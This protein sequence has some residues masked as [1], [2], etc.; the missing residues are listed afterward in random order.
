MEVVINNIITLKLGE[1]GYP[2]MFNQIYNPPKILYAIGN[3]ELLNSKCISMVGTR[4]PTLYG[5]KSAVNIARNLSDKGITVVSGLAKGIDAMSHEGALQGKSKATIAVLGNSLDL[6]D[7]YPS[8]NEYLYKKILYENGCIVS[9][10]PLGTKAEKWRFLERNRLVA[11][12]GQSLI[13]VEATNHS[14]TF[15]TVDYALDQGKSIYAVPGN[16]DS[17]KSEGCNSLI[18]Q[19]ANIFISVNKMLN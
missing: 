2:K 4:N 5:I 10:Y 6:N 11:G 16:I 12:L 9:E 7:L 17:L 14:G 15:S 3:I 1:K 19:G 13:V 8:E 18:E